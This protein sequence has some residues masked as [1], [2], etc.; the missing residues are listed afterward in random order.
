MPSTHYRGGE[1]TLMLYAAGQP[2]SSFATEVGGDFAPLL[3][4]PFYDGV[5]ILM[6]SQ[7][8]LGSPYHIE[9]RPVFGGFRY[10]GVA[11]FVSHP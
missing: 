2:K 1:E 8:R 9:E 7:P 5:S 6:G 4:F 11:F 3:G 10:I